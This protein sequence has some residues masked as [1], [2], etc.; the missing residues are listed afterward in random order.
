MPILSISSTYLFPHHNSLN[1]L[2]TEPGYQDIKRQSL[3]MLPKQLNVN[4]Y[5]QSAD[6]KEPMQQLKKSSLTLTSGGGGVTK[7]CPTLATP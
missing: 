3:N 1:K 7:S 4:I 5:K 6:S 2:P